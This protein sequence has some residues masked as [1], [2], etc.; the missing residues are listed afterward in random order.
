VSE[1]TPGDEHE[2]AVIAAYMRLIERAEATVADA[3]AQAQG[4]DPEP[5]G[6]PCP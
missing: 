6:P 5:D 3:A 4:L 2:E 1:Q